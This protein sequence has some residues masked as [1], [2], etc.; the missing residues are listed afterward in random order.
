MGLRCTTGSLPSRSLRVT[1][2]VPEISGPFCGTLQIKYLQSEH[3][4]T[5]DITMSGFETG[6]GQASQLQRGDSFADRSPFLQAQGTSGINRGSI[7]CIAITHI[8]S[9][10]LP[11]LFLI[12]EVQTTIPSS[13]YT[14]STG[15]FLILVTI[16]LLLY[17]LLCL[18]Y[19]AGI[20]SFFLL[21]LGVDFRRP[22]P[23]LK[24][25]SMGRLR[26]PFQPYF[27]SFSMGR[28]LPSIP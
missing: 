19:R 26:H 20:R 24:Y 11:Q 8:L 21:L 7:L 25:D 2:N 1:K 4:L 13:R 17:C 6:A 3:P 15:N 16:I 18:I 14:L 12:R 28:I 9:V 10:R 5:I 27:L 23:G 22:I